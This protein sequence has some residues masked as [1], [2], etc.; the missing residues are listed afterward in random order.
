M[1]GA[2]SSPEQFTQ[3]MLE[4]NMIGLPANADGYQQSKNEILR[5]WQSLVGHEFPQHRVAITQPFY[6]GMFEVTQEQYEAVMGGHPSHHRQA[7]QLPVENVS[8]PEAVRFCRKLS[9]LPAEKSSG[10]TYRLPTEAEWEYACRAGTTD[11]FPFETDRVLEQANVDGVNVRGECPNCLGY[12]QPVGQYPPN[13]FGLHDMN[14]NVWEW[15][16][17]SFDENEYSN[18]RTFDPKGPQIGKFHI[19][20][21]GSFEYPALWARSSSRGPIW[22]FDEDGST[23]AYGTLGDEDDGFRIV[24]EIEGVT[25]LT[26]RKAFEEESS[27]DRGLD[28]SETNWDKVFTQQFGKESSADEIDSLEYKPE[29]D[30]TF[31]EGSSVTE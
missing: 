19:L 26:Y 13:N 17:D 18:S 8:W 14:G 3:E 5:D 21:G 11:L 20:R 7:E 31:S 27:S 6:M 16:Q 25:G 9:E 15:C 12:P 30:S 22:S 4:S 28:F 23:T 24:M 2:H 1:M 29:L 10:R